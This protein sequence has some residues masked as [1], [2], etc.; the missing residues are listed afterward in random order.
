M[1]EELDKR[2]REDNIITHTDETQ[3]S[4]DVKFAP[5][6][7]LTWIVAILFVLTGIMWLGY[8]VGLLAALLPGGPG[9]MEGWIG[10]IIGVIGVVMVVLLIAQARRR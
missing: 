3:A 6:A 9:L 7:L 10:G 1:T 5:L 4:R 8:A 2:P